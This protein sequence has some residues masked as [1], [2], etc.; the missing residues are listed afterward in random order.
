MAITTP[1]TAT[2]TTELG[3]AGALGADV[4][5]VDVVAVAEVVDVVVVDV[6]GGD[7]VD[8]V[9]GMK[10]GDMDLSQLVSPA[11]PVQTAKATS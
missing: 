5:V 3:I 7:D 11:F 8:M 9:K 2:V 4:V 1:M 10:L 6:I